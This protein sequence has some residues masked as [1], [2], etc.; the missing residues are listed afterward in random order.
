MS[1][2][3][4]SQI[5]IPMSLYAELVKYAVTDQEVPDLKDKL[6]K[7][8]YEKADKQ[9]AREKY[10]LWKS[11]STPEEK[12]KARKEYIEMRMIPSDYRY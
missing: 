2:I 9:A 1:K 4:E 11:G 7:F 6:K 10:T 5:Q 12:E 3:K 8:I